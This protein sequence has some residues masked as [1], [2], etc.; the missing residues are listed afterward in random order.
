MRTQT[1]YKHKTKFRNP[2]HQNYKHIKTLENVKHVEDIVEGK[3]ENEICPKCGSAM[4]LRTAKKGV[5]AGNQFWG[6]SQFPECRE[7]L[8]T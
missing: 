6:C 1:I 2:L 8:T 3:Q 5:N 4:I 7:T